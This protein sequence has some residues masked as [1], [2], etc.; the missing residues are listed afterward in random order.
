MLNGSHIFVGTVGFNSWD[1]FQ[2]YFSFF[3]SENFE[4]FTT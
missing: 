2:K 4:N 3:F 1:D